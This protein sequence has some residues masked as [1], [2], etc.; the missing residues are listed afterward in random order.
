M[1]DLASLRERAIVLMREA[2]ELLD[3]AGEDVAAQHLQ[4]AH[5]IAARVPPMQPGDEIDF[6]LNPDAV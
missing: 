5:D 2:L 6:E 4:W 1:M 3:E